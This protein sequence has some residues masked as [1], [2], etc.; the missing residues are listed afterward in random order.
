MK[1]DQYSDS[2]KSHDFGDSDDYCSKCDIRKRFNTNKCPT[3]KVHGD[4]LSGPPIKVLS[5]R[6]LTQ[7][8]LGVS[9]TIYVNVDSPN[10]GFPYFNYSIVRKSHPV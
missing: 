7:A 10:L 5:T 4:F 8:R 3:V 1:S 6:K 2:G 9:R